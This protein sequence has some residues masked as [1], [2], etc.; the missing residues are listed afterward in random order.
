MRALRRDLWYTT[1]LMLQ[2]FGLTKSY[3]DTP[4]FEEISF[5]LEK[6]EILGLVGRNGSGKS[7]LLKILIGSE[8]ADSGSF[9]TPKGYRLGYLE[10]H[11]RFTRPTLLEECTQV[12]GEDERYDYYKAEK[13][14]FGLGF[15]KEDLERAPGEF[16]GG[17]QLRINLTKTLLQSPDLLL[18]DEPTNYLDILSM[19]W[20]RGFLKSF[21]GEVIIV[22]HDRDFMD[23]VTTHTMG[24]HRGR[25][26]KIKGPTDNYYTQLL[27]KEELHEKTRQNQETKIRELQRFVNRFGAKASKAAQAK[28]KQRQIERIKLL[29]ELRSEYT[30]G[31][32]FNFKP[33][34]AKILME[35]RDL[36]F[37]YSGLDTDNLFSSLDFEIKPGDRLAVIGKNGK[38]KT[39]LLDI[40]AG[41]LEPSSGAIRLHPRSSTGYYQQTN[42]KD[43]NPA[44]TVAEEIALA[45]PELNTTQSRSICG[46]MM[47]PG[48]QADKFISVL[49]GGEQSRVLLG[50][51]L[52]H[53]A[54]LLLLDEPSNHLD[55]DSIEVMTQE[56]ARFPGGVIIVTH[57]EEILRTLANKLIV[58]RAGGA[59]LFTGTYDEFLDRVGWDEE[60]QIKRPKGSSTKKTD[61]K[62]KGKGKGKG[63]G[64]L[65][66]EQRLRLGAAKREYE[67]TEQE[68][69]E[70]EDRL[71]LKNDEAMSLATEGGG[72][73]GELRKI[74]E[75]LGK[76]QQTIEDHYSRLEKLTEEIVELDT[77]S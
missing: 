49:S 44:R 11:I 61:V 20:L 8:G 12:L 19:R 2:V 23:S 62:A 37:S 43:L 70:L 58:F 65:I 36:A 50:K 59:E 39:T 56:I 63:E 31:F 71:K 17:F 14:L 64:K 38:G 26:I 46:A 1:L 72:G 24:I 48:D 67:K 60:D 54:N 9:T 55:M 51:V 27:I 52:A 21:R 53:P 5:S 3:E 28:S 75:D 47:F 33:T 22:T 30:L 18:L 4:L 25:L 57:N 74:Y 13:I 6:N 7:T 32:C 34:P 15:T 41:S 68:I 69:L 45:N 29:S 77:S 73:N 10:Q 76:L 35:V 40:L 42:R 66:K 16:S